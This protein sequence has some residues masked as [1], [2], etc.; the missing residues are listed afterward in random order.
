MRT[1]N[2]TAVANGEVKRTEVKGAGPNGARHG[3]ATAPGAR[4]A[5]AGGPARPPAAAARKRR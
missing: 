3:R 5:P 4:R 1:A 2:A